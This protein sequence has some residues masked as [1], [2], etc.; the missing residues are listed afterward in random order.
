MTK[1]TLV[2]CIPREPG[3]RV[4]RASAEKLAGI[5]NRH[6]PFGGKRVRLL[7]DVCNEANP[8]SHEIRSVKELQDIFEGT[9]VFLPLYGLHERMSRMNHREYALLD[10]KPVLEDARAGKIHFSG[11]GKGKCSQLL[12]RLNEILACEKG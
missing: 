11:L 3:T 12:A 4:S 8:L 7:V 1:T 6:S 2:A 10:L 9:N 5:L